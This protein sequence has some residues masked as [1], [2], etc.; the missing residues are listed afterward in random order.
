MI[1]DPFRVVWFVGIVFHELRPIGLRP[2]LL[3]FEARWAYRIHS[4]TLRTSFSAME[5]TAD[6]H[7]FGIMN[8][9]TKDHP[10]GSI[11][12]IDNA[13]S[14]DEGTPGGGVRR[15]TYTYDEELFGP[16]AIVIRA[17]DQEHAMEI[18]N[19]SR[20]GLGG[21]VWT[22]DT[23]RGEALARCLQSGAAFVNEFVKSDPRL[24]FGGV[25]A[26]GYGRELCHHGLREF[27]NAKTVWIYLKEPCACWGCRP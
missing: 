4:A 23:Q 1:F 22:K 12:V 11:M 2:R 18:A 21:S 10:Y 13:G 15:F 20:F 6:G 3:L 27:V 7:L 17:R 26:S 5:K 8:G 25:K 24:P 19:G 9:E 14:S 16:V